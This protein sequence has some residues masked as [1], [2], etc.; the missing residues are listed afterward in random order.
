MK[1]ILLLLFG[2]LPL[3][4]YAQTDSVLVLSDVH[5]DLSAKK[6]TFY[7]EDTDPALFISAVKNVKPGNFP[8]I[9]MPGD[10][11]PHGDSHSD[12]EMKK[13]CQYILK[14]VQ[15][16]AKDAIILPALGNNDCKSHNSPDQA[17][18]AVFYDAMLK[19][20]DHHDSIAKTFKEGG[21]YSYDK[22]DLSIIM[23]NTLLFAFGPDSAAVQ[24][25][26]W[27]GKTL[28][29]DRRINK[30]VWIVYHIPPGIDRYTGGPSWHSDIQ[31]MYLDTIKKYASVIKFQLAGHTH[32][33]DIRLITDAGKL[34]SYIAIAPGLDTRNGNNPAYQV[35]HYNTQD[36]MINAIRTYYTDSLSNYRWHTVDFKAFD[37]NFLLHFESQ[38]SKG[39]DF[40]RNY[41][42]RRG[43]LKSKNGEQIGWDARFCSESIIA[44]H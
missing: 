43:P 32:M 9:I 38:S 20:I 11:L 1:K 12:A 35:I 18:Y 42:I 15:H 21:Y 19:R 23:M 26:K 17:T 30:R 2:V 41:P 14:N 27:L 29:Q 7:R 22:E 40:V 16:I 13:T 24:E 10:L 25:L 31:Q 3:T 39:A 44:L 4:G 34:I 8:F 36:K 6:N 33:N 37:F 28:A 5:V